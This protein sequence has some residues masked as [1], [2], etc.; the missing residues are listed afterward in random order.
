MFPLQ[1]ILILKQQLRMICVG[2]QKCM[3]SFYK[4]SNSIADRTTNEQLKDARRAVFENKKLT[5]M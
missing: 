1:F 3:L 2:S 5:S 4:W